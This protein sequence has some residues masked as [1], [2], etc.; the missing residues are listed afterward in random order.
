MTTMWA[1]GTLPPLYSGFDQ[2]CQFLRWSRTG[3]GC[4]AVMS[5]NK[6][7]RVRVFHHLSVHEIAHYILA[8]Q[9]THHTKRQSR[10]GSPEVLILYGFK[11]VILAT[12]G[13]LF[14]NES[15]ALAAKI[16]QTTIIALSSVSDCAGVSNAQLPDNLMDITI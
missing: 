3:G 13:K 4:Q 9:C 10:K 11:L 2:F 12:D 14:N 1:A 8:S 6:Q 7:Y 16:A 15:P 5:N